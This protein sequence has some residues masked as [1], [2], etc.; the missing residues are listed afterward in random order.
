MMTSS[1]LMEILGYEDMR[2]LRKW[3]EANDVPLIKVGLRYVAHSWT[4]EV[5]LLR[6]FQKEAYAFGI[7][8]EALVNALVNDNKVRVAHLLSAPLEVKEERNFSSKKSDANCDDVIN[9][10]K[11]KSA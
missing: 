8:G 9:Q 7:D 4:V 5:A 11:Q 2:S 10:F 1:Q 3:C 6:I